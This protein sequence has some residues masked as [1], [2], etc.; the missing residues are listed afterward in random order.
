MRRLFAIGIFVLGAASGAAVAVAVL[1]QTHFGHRAF[2]QVARHCLR[3]PDVTSTVPDDCP[4][5]GTI[6]V[7][8]KEGQTAGAAPSGA[9]EGHAGQG[10]PAAPAAATATAVAGHAAITLDP[11]KLQKINV[12]FG[13]VERRPATKTFR[14]VA[15]IE[16]DERRIFHVHTKFEGWITKLHVAYVGAKVEAGAPLVT[17]YS[18]AV[19][20]AEEEYRLARRSRPGVAPD[21]GTEDT[22]TTSARRKLELWDIP[23]DEIARLDRGEAP[24][25]DVQL[26]APISGHVIAKEALQGL[27]FQPGSNLYTVA[28]L[29]LVWV[30]ARF[31]ER[32][33]PFVASGAAV[34]LE[35]PAI[36]GRQLAGKIAY[37]YPTVDPETRT[38]I[39]RIEVRNDDLLL[40][41]GMFANV[42]LEASLGERVMAP[43]GAV[44]RAGERAF[45][46]VAHEGGHFEP[47]EVK[48]GLRGEG[49]VEVLSGLA[50]GE[51]V[52]TSANFLIDSESRLRAAIEGMG[53]APGGHG[54]H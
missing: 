43:D 26:R 49:W 27:F 25:K 36:P 7:P 2:E 20:T 54:G 52:T 32:D 50:A 22:L 47:R 24:A 29:S 6:M 3:H 5:C 21:A 12:R 41:P 51:R 33:L 46:F 23:Q 44:L 53:M 40:K 18:P 14:T 42:T 16:P 11:A 19:L 38:I 39:A 31:Y 10:M 13:M 1:S 45:A 4:I 37:L 9:H 15:F 8:V 17:V 28:D 34:A 30:Q 35:V 48:L